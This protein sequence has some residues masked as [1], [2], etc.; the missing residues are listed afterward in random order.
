MTTLLK[1]NLNKVLKIM[2]ST[3]IL[4]TNYIRAGIWSKQVIMSLW[5]FSIFFWYIQNKFYFQ[6]EDEDSKEIIMGH[7]HAGNHPHLIIVK[8]VGPIYSF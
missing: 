8:E 6:I 4:S 1:E 3:I 2:D 7:N 5:H